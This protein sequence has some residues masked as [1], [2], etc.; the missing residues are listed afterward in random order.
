[1]R[2]GTLLALLCSLV[3]FFTTIAR[4]AAEDP[5]DLFIYSVGADTVSITGFPKGAA[6]KIVIPPVIEG[7]PVTL[8]GYAAF[9]NCTRITSVYIP[10]SV[11]SIGAYAFVGCRGIG[12]LRL[13]ERLVNLGLRSFAGCTSLRTV[14]FPANLATIGELSFVRCTL[15]SSVII[16]PGVSAISWGAFGECRNLMSV[17]LPPTIT[18]LGNA[19]FFKCAGLREVTFLGNAP[20]MGK[21]VF[22][23]IHGDFTVRCLAENYG[24][25]LPT[26]LGYPCELAPSIPE[27]DVQEPLGTILKDGKARKSFGTVKIGKTGAGRVFT[28]SNVG[29]A[30]L[31]GMYTKLNGPGAGDFK[32]QVLPS[33]YL[34]P[35]GSF[36]FK[37]SFKPKVAGPRE[38]VLRLKSNDTSENSFDIKLTGTGG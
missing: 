19:V 9:A 20:V 32:V 6:G 13:S 15:L 23:S 1:M 12:E 38:A 2:S 33:S 24:F 16:P 22:S 11:T 18:H 4:L 14:K 29:T 7:K 34:E 8:I 31:G 30:I 27:I 36:T 5:N 26:W 37:V 10:D 35:A 17:T 28:V 25:D 21:Q 3:A